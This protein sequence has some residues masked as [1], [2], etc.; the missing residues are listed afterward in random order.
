MKERAASWNVRVV[1][2]PTDEAKIG[3]SLSVAVSDRSTRV[4]ANAVRDGRG[5]IAD[6][7]G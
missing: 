4:K 5:A 1:S 7:S 3:V 6:P 2:S